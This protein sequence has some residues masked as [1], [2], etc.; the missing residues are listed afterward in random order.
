MYLTNPPSPIVIA[1]KNYP[2]WTP[3]GVPG[4]RA[5][6]LAVSVNEDEARELMPSLGQYVPG[7][8]ED[9]T[10]VQFYVSAVSPDQVTLIPEMPARPESL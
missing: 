6:Q 3:V 2:H 7:L 10:P 1:G 4:R 8:L 5:T 9:G